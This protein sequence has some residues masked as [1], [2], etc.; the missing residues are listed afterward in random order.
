[1]PSSLIDSRV[2][3]GHVRADIGSRM[4]N[5]LP[6]SSVVTH[7]CR[8]F[9]TSATSSLK[10]S[11]G[12]AEVSR[13]KAVFKAKGTALSDNTVSIQELKKGVVTPFLGSRL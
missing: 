3:R 11:R 1:M 6:G 12:V 7:A 2:L 10:A 13:S 5:A 4:V 9:D 8:Q